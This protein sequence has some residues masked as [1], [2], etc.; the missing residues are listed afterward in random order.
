VR[1]FSVE[2][3]ERTRAGMWADSREALGDMDLPGRERVLDVGCGTGELTRVLVEEVE[4][5]EVVGVDADVDLL[6]VAREYAPVVAGDALVLPVAAGA[7]DLVVCQA[8]LVNL[9]DPAAALAEFARVSTD[10]VAAVE[11]DNAAV[12]VDSS[13]DGEADLEGQARAAY[14]DG[15]E[16]DAALGGEGTSAASKRPDWG[17]SGRPGTSTSGSSSRRTTRPTWRTPAGRPPGRAWT[18]TAR[19]CSVARWTPRGTRTSVRTGGRWAA[20]WSRRCRT[21]TTAGSSECRSTSPSDWSDLASS[22]DG[23]CGWLWGDE[24]QLLPAGRYPE[25]SGV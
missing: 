13:V 25:S 22:G 23:P 18:T 16:T 12:T 6:A 2:Y 1:R 14:L 24:R 11:P 10:F 19:R 20:R 5:G 8:L 3:L 9:P 7:V 21:A 15:V 4:D 17:T